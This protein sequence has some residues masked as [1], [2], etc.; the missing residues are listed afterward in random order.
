MGQ[1]R[2]F[3]FRIVYSP[4]DD[5][6]N[7]FYIPALSASVRYDRS[8]GFFSS[9][10]LAVAAAGVARLIQNHGHMRLL[11]GAALS[12]DDVTAIQQ[13]HDLKDHITQRLLERFP[14]PQDALMRERLQV[15]AW[16]VADGTLEIKVVLPRDEHGIPLPASQAADYYHSKTGIFTDLAGDQIA[17]SGSI[18]ESET[19]WNKN[20]ENFSVY[21]SWNETAPYLA[22][23]KIN[24]E[25]LWNGT[26]KDWIALDIPDAVQEQ[27]LKYRP[28][29]PPISDPLER[30]PAAVAEKKRAGIPTP[31]EKIIFQFLRDAPFLPTAIELGAAT[32]AI[33][34]WP[35]QT[36]VANAILNRF[37]DRAMLCDEV[38]LGKTIEAGMAIRQLVISKRVQRCL[39][40]APK[41]VLRQWQE[42]LYEKFALN[43]PRYDGGKFYNAQNQELR[44]DDPNPWNAFDL[45]IAGSQLAKRAD[46]RAEILQTKNWDLIVVDEA[47]HAR[48]KDFKEHIYRPNQLLGLLNDMNSKGKMTALL[49]MT[50][51]PM[52]VHPLEVWDLLSTLGLG[53]RWGA[54][55]EAFLRYFTQL[56]NPFHKVE[57]DFVFDMMRDHLESGGE[58]DPHFEAEAKSALGAV[59]WELLRE[60]PVLRGNRA[61]KIKELGETSR[62][63]VMQMAKRHTPMSRYMYRNTRELLREYKRR[64]WMKDTVPVRKPK[65]ERIRMSAAEEE[66]YNRIDEYISN[67]YYKYEN[68]RRG[69][70]FVMTVYR[71]RLTSSFYAVQQSLKRRLQYLK[72]QIGEDVYLQDDDVEQD[73]L[74]ADVLESIAGID[75]EYFKAEL[76][77]VSDFVQALGQFGSN[78]SKLE[79]L[80]G[81]LD[82]IFRTYSTV[83]VFTQYTDTMDYLRAQLLEV[84][85]SGIG[86]YSGR[87]GEI[88]NGIAWVETTKEAVK[89][90]FREGKIRILVCTDSASEGLNLQTCGVMINYDMP[91]N[92]MRVEQR[93]GRIDRIGQTYKEVHISNLFYMDTIEDQIYQRLKDRIAWFETIVGDLQPILAEVGE[94][95]RRLAMVSSKERQALLDEEIASLKRRLQQREF[96]S[97]DINSFASDEPPQMSTSSPVTLFQLE[98]E[99]VHSE[100]LGNLFEPHPSIPGAYHLT[101]KGETIPV[102]FS[103]EC[104][105][106]HPDTVRFLTYGSDLLDELL[107]SLPDE[108]PEHYGIV[109]YEVENGVE[110][111][112]WYNASSNSPQPITSLVELRELFD[113]GKQINSSAAELAEKM[114]R[115]QTSYL[116]EKVSSVITT[117]RQAYRLSLIARGRDIL[118]KGACIEVALGRNPELFDSEIYPTAFSESVVTGLRRH[119]FPWTALIALVNP[120]EIFLREDNPYFLS[121]TNDSK[122]KLRGRFAQLAQEARRIVSNLA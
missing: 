82:K 101:W 97:L 31:Q 95:T 4:A 64:G 84:Y 58:L 93:I 9:S 36:R 119:G 43:I 89:N 62:P 87:G 24:F 108:K 21:F 19:A 59:K 53:G 73:D 117:R 40:L 11:V 111:V 35:H 2:D 17:F 92:P 38:G 14:D 63:L 29:R 8:A 106:L 39:I 66:L 77:Y 5:P 28:S 26:E 81:E 105:D 102:T 49:L 7:N 20:Y 98:E 27:L 67:F 79:F 115:Q 74:Q 57:W 48:R 72:G 52:Q 110:L 16:M 65:I 60:L 69:L 112:G 47:H 121:I 55:E 15:L 113:Q 75:R 41:S 91:W 45:L 71:R 70:G 96:E 25:R 54:D 86:C 13:G 83:L 56:R 94:V 68:E 118:V 44:A 10:A 103:A 85:G 23:H 114:F 61:S 122:E 76:E 78:D 107:S 109:R 42:E 51:T 18:N 100:A 90:D 116:Q 99:L 46:R 30:K 6:L 33:R 80:K 88:W 37:P 50:A 12:E 32:S 104:F 1:L 34:P 120:S 22:Q 3:S